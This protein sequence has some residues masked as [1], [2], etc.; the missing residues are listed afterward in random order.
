MSIN[1]QTAQAYVDYKTNPTTS[2]SQEF[3]QTHEKELK[4]YFI[5]Q[6]ISFL[7]LL[8]RITQ[9]L[10]HLPPKQ[11][12]K[13]LV[14]NPELFLFT[15]AD[16]QICTLSSK[17]PPAQ[18]WPQ[19]RE[20]MQADLYETYHTTALFNPLFQ[21]QIPPESIPPARL[22]L[23]IYP[24]LFYTLPSHVRKQLRA[25][26]PTQKITKTIQRNFNEMLPALNNLSKVLSQTTD[27]SAFLRDLPRSQGK[28]LN[29]QPLSKAISH[30]F[31]VLL[32]QDAY[33]I[34][35]A[36]FKQAIY[37]LSNPPFFSTSH[38]N[39]DP[40]EIILKENTFRYIYNIPL[41]DSTHSLSADFDP[42]R[43]AGRVQFI[44][45]YQIKGTQIV[46]PKIEQISFQTK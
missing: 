6:K 37:T 5:S 20:Q 23:L 35:L 8:Q 45:S 3:F 33:G 19:F 46:G 36:L 43:T 40:L 42:A 1:L 25:P 9:N 15:I 16:L 21:A 17:L 39:C 11:R 24:E 34:P 38:N 18:P 22:A 32:S 29:G 26:F 44:F 13:A 12:L 28:T 27:R 2:P 4:Q 7:P 10:T 31:S 41:T 14:D 30:P